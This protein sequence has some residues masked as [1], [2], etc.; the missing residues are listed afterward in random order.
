MKQRCS[1]ADAGH[2]VLAG[3][4]C[5]GQRCTAMH[6]KLAATVRKSGLGRCVR[7]RALGFPR[8]QRLIQ[9]A[10]VQDSRV[11]PVQGYPLLLAICIASQR[12]ASQKTGAH[13]VELASTFLRMLNP[14]KG[15]RGRLRT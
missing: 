1:A 4:T 12:Y 14:C 3:D 13:P 6:L 8:C 2:A 9:N 7:Q 15:T 11:A 10:D 5:K